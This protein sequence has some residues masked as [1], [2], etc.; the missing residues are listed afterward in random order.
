MKTIKGKTTWKSLT[1]NNNKREFNNN[2]NNLQQQ[3]LYNKKILSHKIYFNPV[4]NKYKKPPN[5]NKCKTPPNYSK[6]HKNKNTTYLK[7]KQTKIKKIF[8]TTQTNKTLL[9]NLPNTAVHQV[10]LEVLMKEENNKIKMMGMMGKMTKLNNFKISNKLKKIPN[11]QSKILCLMMIS[12]NKMKN[13]PHKDLS[14]MMNKNYKK[15]KLNNKANYLL[16]QVKNYLLFNLKNNYSQNN[17]LNRLHSTLNNHLLNKL[18]KN[19]M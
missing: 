14:G 7:K 2:K 4:K 1:M 5:N 6:I 15:N 16:F 11:N 19:K 18:S 10:Y 17:L 9:K 12:L 3:K 8:L 13:N